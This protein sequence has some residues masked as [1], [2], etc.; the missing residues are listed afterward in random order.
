MAPFYKKTFILF[1]I[2]YLF[3]YVYT[4]EEI[5]SG[6][7]AGSSC[8][9]ATYSSLSDKCLTQNNNFC[10]TNL[11]CSSEGVC[12]LDNT[13]STCSKASECFGAICAQSQCSTAK[14]NGDLCSTNDE[15]A[16]NLCS[17]GV[18]KGLSLGSSCSQ[19]NTNHQCDVGLYC[20]SKTKTCASQLSDG[21]N[22]Y[23]HLDTN[24]IDIDI[25]CGPGYVCDYSP[26]SSAKSGTCK[27]MLSEKEGNWCNSKK[28]CSLG[29]ACQNNYCT[30]NFAQCN[31]DDSLFCPEGYFCQC[32]EGTS[33]NGTCNQTMNTSCQTQLEKY[34]A[35]LVLSDCQNENLNENGTCSFINCYDELREFECCKTQDGFDHSYYPTNGIICKDCPYTKKFSK[36]GQNCNPSSNLNC[37][38]NLFCNSNTG[39]CEEDNTGSSC[40]N[41]NEC[42][43]G[44]CSNGKCSI[45][46]NNGENCDSKAECYSNT[47]N[48]NY[49]EGKLEGET[50]DPSLLVGNQCD[51]NLFCNSITGKCSR[52][53]NPKEECY[54]SLLPYLTDYDQVCITGYF[55][56]PKPDYKSGYCKE[57]YSEKENGECGS[58]LSCE[59]GQACQDN[60]C[61]K[62]YSNCNFNTKLCPFGFYCSCDSDQSTGECIEIE[63]SSCNVTFLEFSE[64]LKNYDCPYSESYVSGTCGYDRCYNE[65]RSYQCCLRSG[66]ITTFYPYNGIDCSTCGNNI[67]YA[68]VS[69]GCSN[70]EHIQCYPNLFCNPN[71]NK[72]EKDNT[73]SSCQNG[74]E[75][76]G[77]VCVNSKCSGVVSNGEFCIS[78]VQ[79]YSNNCTRYKCSGSGLGSACD[80]TNYLSDQC[81][82]GLYCS[83]KT[84]KC[85]SQLYGGQECVSNLKPYFTD[86][87]RIC[88]GGYICDYSIDLESGYCTRLFSGEK[89]DVCS[90]VKV[91]ELGL[92]CRNGVC[93]ETIDDCD[94]EMLS[95]PY[96]YYCDCNSNQYG[97]N[98]AHG[99]SKGKCVQ[100]QN[101]NCQA[102]I[103]VFIN[104]LEWKNCF[105]QTDFISGTCMASKCAESLRNSQCCFLNGF[106]N[107]Y[108]VNEGIDCKTCILHYNL[109]G[110]NE[111]CTFD[112]TEQ[113]YKNLFCNPHTNKCEK[114]NTGSKCSKGTEC[115]GGICSS[116]KCSGM[117]DNGDQCSTDQECWNENCVNNICKGKASNEVCDPSS[118]NGN[119]CDKGLFCDSITEKCISQLKEGEECASHLKPYYTENRRICQSGYDCDPQDD[120]WDKAI[121]R[122]MFSVEN[123]GNCGSS[124]V[125]NVDLACQD[126]KCTND[127]PKCDQKS[128]F[129]PINYYCDCNSNLLDGQCKQI[130]NT[131][132]Q[133][134][135]EN[136]VNCL[137]TKDCTQPFD[138]IIGTCAYDHCQNE[139]RQLQCCFSSGNYHSMSYPNKGLECYNCETV[140]YKKEN[141]QCN[142]LN[143]ELCYANLFCNPISNM[144]AKDNTGSNCTNGNEC[145]G[146]ICSN[147]KCSLIKDN[148][149]DCSTSQEC[150][151]R[152]CF[153]QHCSGTPEGWK[154]DPSIPNDNQCNQGL[155]CNSITAK[156]ESQLKEGEE[157]ASHLKPYYTQSKSICQSGYVCDPQDANFEKGY[158]KRI[159]SSKLNENCG[160]S[161]VCEK[162]LACQD[163]KCT[164][165][166]TNCDQKSFFCPLGYYCNCNSNQN[167]GTCVQYSNDKNCQEI[168]MEFLDCLQLH[169]CKFRNDM[170]NGVCMYENCKE[171]AD[172]LECCKKKTFSKTY[173]L[174]NQINCEAC[175]EIISYVSISKSCNPEKLTYCNDNLFCNSNT[176]I[177]MK[178]NTGSSC[179]NGSECYGG[180]CSNGKCSIM[181]NNGEK[182]DSNKVCWG[183]LCNFGICQGKSLG[184]KCDPYLLGGNDCDQNLFCDSITEKCIDSIQKNEECISHLSPWFMDTAYV[185]QPGFYCDQNVTSP[186]IQG[187]CKR[188]YS[189]WEGMS[190]GSSLVCNLGLACQN[191]TC[192]SDF[193]NC[194]EH[195]LF[196][197]H[198]WYCKCDRFFYKGHC[199]QTR[200][201]DCS[202]ES[203]RLNECIERKNCPHEDQLT[204]GTCAFSNCF[205]ELSAFQCCR[206]SGFSSK[207]FPNIKIDCKSCAYSIK[208]NLLGQSC[209]VDQNNYCVSN[210]WCSN[211]NKCEKDNTGSK[212][213]KGTECY[214]GICSSGKCSGMKDNGDQCSTDQECLNGNC[215]N[216]IC[217]GKA[218][219]EECDPSTINGRDCD[220]GLFCDS[221]TETCINQIEPNQQCMDHLKPY[222][223]NYL[224]VCTPGY[225]CDTEDLDYQTGTCKRFYSGNENDKCGSSETC[226][227][228]YGCQDNKCT[229]DFW[230]CDLKKKF[231]PVGAY[232]RCNNNNITGTCK[233]TQNKKCQNFADELIGCKIKNKCGIVPQLVPQTCDW[234]N[235]FEQL[236]NY[237]CC[238]S[239]DVYQEIYYP[240]N[241]IT[242]N[243]PSPSAS[244]SPSLTPSVSPSLSTSA[245]PVKSL[246]NVKLGLGVGLPLALLFVALGSFLFFGK[247]KRK[248]KHDYQQL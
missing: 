137:N 228:A 233:F 56:D 32:N 179:S 143:N 87:E 244:P 60:K 215:V 246:S 157:C 72:C 18:C 222:Y 170:P 141:E 130:A 194:D 81:D 91:C 11:W 15:C 223:S 43:G 49:C 62:K 162:G 48:S 133:Y 214:G 44:I 50:C 38:E 24:L 96:G 2:Y 88:T 35:C 217:K 189:G 124:L 30:S 225:I 149:D 178:D 242:C 183:G 22:C 136:Y 151:S 125:C 51:Q 186:S 77:G 13:G 46:K 129:C 103:S 23:S 224:S 134:Q 175:S 230:T 229:S 248:Q 10:F 231:C 232:C 78:D 39:L 9:S 188:L 112:Y 100:I 243:R 181:K 102:E 190:C 144:C 208:Y 37:Y 174:N 247:H 108:Y 187:Y 211:E 240:N 12:E 83:S 177:C 158:C 90:N 191:N 205:D 65:L 206:Q 98:G 119:V 142:P 40:T 132:C 29:L 209:N 6:N 47:C 31:I 202:I 160:S 155:Y 16:S 105:F 41:G 68:K 238:L 213:S 111:N 193:K 201:D 52:S 203:F 161:L 226:Q 4:C 239:E 114:D 199:I 7:I 94:S 76:Y 216:N 93:S 74:E 164:N 195:S 26:N 27:L 121:C 218:I 82:Y 159:W 14:I 64:C 180:I 126:F 168:S 1:V 80:P 110:L 166:F 109:N 234:E 172:D 135:A 84:S 139:A 192:T 198:G 184:Q 220:K 227:L 163:F 107:S 3:T 116:G 42:Y 61:T 210:L 122:K 8:V 146:G 71:T 221:I 131:D 86:W 70:L 173:Y 153:N 235:C 212:C 5:N 148:G 245:V 152:N 145:Y 113:C 20:D 176:G 120:N 219:N 117:K 34:L 89:G 85:E 33:G 106:E 150:H 53:F 92:S 36:I 167:N 19:K 140:A 204:V 197:P 54:T 25:M 99:S 165:D 55:C 185:C 73:G 104:C 67:T 63:N 200:N 57:F 147:G 101:T 17:S 123:G 207:Y 59:F 21:D 138:L 115:Y 45:M 236:K 169:D 237:Q 95:C 97:D 127:F 118:I 79:C 196:C 241:G 154:C 69:E 171:L 66:H 128:L 58:K 28:S 182:C 75:C 156:C